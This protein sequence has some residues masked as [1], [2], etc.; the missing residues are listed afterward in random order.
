MSITEL[1]YVSP[2]DSQKLKAYVF[3]V[4]KPKALV[5]VLHGMADHQR[6]YRPLAL[7]L[8]ESGFRVLP[9]DQR[10]HGESLYDG[11]LKGH[12]ADEDGWLHN[13]EDI[14]NIIQQVN[15]QDH[16]PM[17]LFGHSMGSIV[18]RSYLRHYGEDLH[19][20]YLSGSPDESPIAAIGNVIA[21][22][23]V[24]LK[25]KRHPSPLL[26][27]LSFGQ[28]NAN[29][30]NPKTPYDWV[31]VDEENIIAYNQD[32]LCGF[33]CTAKMFVDLLSGIQ[34]VYRTKSWT[35]HNPQLPI[36]LESGR[37]DPCHKPN[38]IERAAKTLNDLGYQSVEYAYVEG[39]RHEIYNDI[40][41][42]ELM[43]S[44]VA[45]CESTL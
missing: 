29:I 18:A 2:F 30:E 41:R 40:S 21:K 25:G 38:G 39:C 23:V 17:I 24:N 42:E 6:R 5:V 13:L 32:P 36:K 11:H 26:T 7:R 45:W 27:K 43:D 3:D 9:I 15:G 28:F 1:K 12:F 10:G 44:F 31:S 4:D 16:Y 8:N 33:D 20:L 22:T 19:A 14:H 35:I 34:E 37:L